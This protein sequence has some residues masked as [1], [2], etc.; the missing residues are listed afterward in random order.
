MPKVGHACKACTLSRSRA[1]AWLV[2]YLFLLASLKAQVVFNGVANKPSP[3]LFIGSTVPHPLRRVK[4]YR[5]AYWRV[6]S[7][8]R[9]SS[10]LFF[11]PRFP[12]AWFTLLTQAPNGA[13]IHAAKQTENARFMAYL[14]ARPAAHTGKS[15][16]QGSVLRFAAPI[17]AR[18]HPSATLT[19]ARWRGKPQKGREGFR[20]PCPASQGPC[21]ASLPASR[22][23]QG[24][25]SLH[26]TQCHKA[27]GKARF[28][29]SAR[30]H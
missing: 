7:R 10:C 13:Q 8:R 14:C 4:V 15:R 26:R 17:M 29:S 11:P 5:R 1:F 30:S 25:R 28:Q 9:S 6:C 23:S 27:Q 19:R 16:C 24:K 21:L 18:C 12:L 22:R 2:V 3:S 20:R